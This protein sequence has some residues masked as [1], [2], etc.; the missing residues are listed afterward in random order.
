MSTAPTL[1]L[2]SVEEY[3]NSSWQPDMEFVDGVLL[4]RN[5]GTLPHGSL[6]GILLVYL[7][8]L[9]REFR[10]RA[11]PET[12]LKVSGRRYRVPDVMVVST[13]LDTRA[14]TYEGVPLIIVEVLS[15]EDRLNDV[16]Q[17]FKD[18]ATLGVPHSIL[19][20]PVER[21]T[22]TFRDGYLVGGHITSLDLPDGRSIPFPTER[23]MA[24]LDEE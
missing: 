13:P 10:I 24:Q 19:L 18:Y 20:D 15:P 14:R 7:D 8:T 2:M 5:V 11:F 6:Q 12:R 3:L 21:V 16:V 23:L 4:E 9:R 22:Y 17:K 1:P